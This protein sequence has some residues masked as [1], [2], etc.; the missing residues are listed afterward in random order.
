[1]RFGAILIA[2][3]VVFISCS[4]DD[5]DFSSIQPPA[6]EIGINSNIFSLNTFCESVENVP[7]K[8][9]TDTF[10][11]GA[12]EDRMIGGTTAEILAQF[13]CAKDWTLPAEVDSSMLYLSISYTGY[14][15]SGDSL[16]NLKVYRMNQS[17]FS[18][19]DKLYPNIDP[20][21]YCDESEKL[22]L[23][24]EISLKNSAKSGSLAILL[25]DAL[26]Q[27]LMDEARKNPSI[28]QD[29]K[30]FTDFFKG[31]YLKVEG[32]SAMLTISQMNMYLKYW[33]QNAGDN[34]TEQTTTFSAN[35][36][37]RQVN[38]IEHTYPSGILDTDTAVYL[39]SPAGLRTSVEIPIKQIQSSFKLRYAD[40]VIKDSADKKV[41]I[42]NA[43]LTFELIADTAASSLEYPPYVVLVKE[44]EIENFFN[45]T[46]Y[47][48]NKTSMLGEY[49]A[50]S[51][52][53]V[54]S[55]RS[56]LASELQKEA[57]SEIDK[58][59]LMPVHVTFDSNG[60][61]VVADYQPKLYAAALRSS[62]GDLPPKL[63]VVLSS[64]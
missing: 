46:K 57:V 54:F 25:D 16:I 44:S 58:L 15:A 2:L 19:G 63:K 51:H 14:V 37:V 9:S 30:T 7:M 36:E 64:F 56:Y 26:C 60:Y 18:Y 55:L 38:R 35:K 62:D 23:V 6:D 61:A 27:S 5:G 34:T 50:A 39:S 1:M 21:L 13:N 17:T 42:N 52:A 8:I 33:Y 43:L 24:D 40:G 59:Y 3:S 29:E 45:I 32:S 41:S 49:N 22:N 12:Y 48:D 10:L 4:D 11:L 53:Y 31:I 20:A 28:Y 47:P